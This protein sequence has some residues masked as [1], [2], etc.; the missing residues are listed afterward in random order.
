[1]L[2]FSYTAARKNV[3]KLVDAGILEQWGE[4]KRGKEFFAK[5]VLRILLGIGDSS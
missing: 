5:E 4:K 3:M 1:M 2:G